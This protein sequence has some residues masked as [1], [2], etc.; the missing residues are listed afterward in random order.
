MGRIIFPKEL[1]M[2]LGV[3]LLLN[4]FAGR[5]PVLYW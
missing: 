3:A 4:L 1:A 2:G 5:V